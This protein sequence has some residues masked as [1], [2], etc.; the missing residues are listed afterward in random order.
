MS[1]WLESVIR[2]LAPSFFTSWRAPARDMSGVLPELASASANR[3]SACPDCL[4]AELAVPMA[5]RMESDQ[6]GVAIEPVRSISC[7]TVTV[8]VGFGDCLQPA[9]AI[10]AATAMVNDFMTLPC[11][12]IAA[13]TAWRGCDWFLGNMKRAPAEIAISA[14]PTTRPSEL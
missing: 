1:S 10:N 14:R 5:R 12:G 6:L 8:A 4:S 3:S 13:A 9:Q 2:T 11:Y 7:P